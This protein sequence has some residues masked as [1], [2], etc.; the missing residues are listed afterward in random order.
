[1]ME[2]RMGSIGNTHG[3]KERPIPSRKN[4][5]RTGHNAACSTAVIPSTSLPPDVVAVPSAAPD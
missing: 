4:S 5:V 1:M 3:V 2:D